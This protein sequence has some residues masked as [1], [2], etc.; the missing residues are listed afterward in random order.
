[1]QVMD[2]NLT[3]ARITKGKNLSNQWSTIDFRSL[4]FHGKCSSFYLILICVFIVY[5]LLFFLPFLLYISL[6][7]FMF[8]SLII[9]RY[10]S[11]WFLVLCSIVFF[12]NI[13]E[14]SAR[15]WHP[16]LLGC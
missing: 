1:M 4:S 10:A 11:C 13:F 12:S 16:L 14:V 2:S 5:Q 6:G 15:K 7:K 3:D 8:V 9:L